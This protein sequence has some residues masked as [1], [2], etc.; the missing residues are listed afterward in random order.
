M[1]GHSAA[2]AREFHLLVLV[3]RISKSARTGL[4][5]F[6]FR[7]SSRE[8]ISFMSQTKEPVNA[9][10]TC[11]WKE[12]LGMASTAIA[13]ESITPLDRSLLREANGKI[14]GMMT[15]PSHTAR[16]SDMPDPTGYITSFM[17]WTP[18][19]RWGTRFQWNHRKAD[20]TIISGKDDGYYSHT[21]ALRDLREFLKE[22]A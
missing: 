7:A 20:G 22:I 21:G 18:T 12:I 3:Q 9:V 13:D 14:A 10:V 5:M 4:T 15:Q 2:I 8:S 11:T 6:S 16:S 1:A 17:G 19:G